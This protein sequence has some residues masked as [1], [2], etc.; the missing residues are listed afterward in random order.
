LRPSNG[1]NPEEPKND[2]YPPKTYTFDVT[3]CEEIFDLLVAD[4]I[5]LVPK[6]LKVTPFEQRKKGDFVNFMVF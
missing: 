1:K 3:K 5:I 2:I 4:G 6:N